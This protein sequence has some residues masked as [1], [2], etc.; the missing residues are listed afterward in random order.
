MAFT[1]EE[2]KRGTEPSSSESV[3]NQ[4]YSPPRATCVHCHRS[5]D[6]GRIIADDVAV[7]D[8]C[9]GGRRT[10]LCQLSTKADM[11]ICSGP[12]LAHQWGKRDE[13][14]HRPQNSSAAMPTPSTASPG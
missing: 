10:T 7:C 5:S 8:I 9:N 13:L 4:S 14:D 3:P 11:G 2:F 6:Y 1:D 12:C